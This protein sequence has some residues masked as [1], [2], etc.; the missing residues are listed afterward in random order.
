MWQHPG[1]KTEAA[2]PTETEPKPFEKFKQFAQAVLSVPKQEI[3]R[4]EA[5]YQDERAALK[6]DKK[7][8]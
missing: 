4:R 8:A 6:R 3:D 5:V 7:P 1:M 2:S